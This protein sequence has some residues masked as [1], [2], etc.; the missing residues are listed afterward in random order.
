MFHI[1]RPVFLPHELGIDTNY[2]SEFK[3]ALFVRALPF[4]AYDDQKV[5]W[6]YT[7]PHGQTLAWSMT[8]EGLYVQVEPDMLHF[9]IE[10][11]GLG[12]VRLT[13]ARLKTIA[14]AH[15]WF[16]V[17]EIHILSA[18]EDLPP[19]LVGKYGLTL[20]RI[21]KTNIMPVANGIRFTREAREAYLLPAMA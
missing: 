17:E 4:G 2:I 15:A 13:I 21:W 16:A 14:H 11:I 6:F 5:G 1:T 20:K 18:R 7:A 9:D 8:E 12:Q 3:D 10:F 19:Y